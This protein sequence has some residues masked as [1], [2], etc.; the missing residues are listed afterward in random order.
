MTGS[1]ILLPKSISYIVLI[2]LFIAGVAEIRQG[3]IGRIGIFL[4]SMFLWQIFY[5][6]FQELPL[7]FQWYLNIGTILGLLAI[8]SYIL[9]ESLPTEY[10]QFCF[11]AYGSISII[12]IF[13]LITNA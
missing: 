8:I 2:G 9:S 1:L 4:N 7:W 10:Y 11:I 6:Q 12:I 13:L 3:H 5:E